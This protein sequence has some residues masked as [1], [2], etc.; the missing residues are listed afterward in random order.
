MVA[1]AHAA[2][3]PHVG[4]L[5]A[6][7]VHGPHTV[8]H[9]CNHTIGSPNLVNG[10]RCAQITDDSEL[11]LALASGLSQADP[12]VGAVVLVPGS[13]HCTI[14]RPAACRHA[15]PSCYTRLQSQPA[16]RARRVQ[17]WQEG[18]YGAHLPHLIAAHTHP[19]SARFLNGHPTASNPA[20]RPRSRRASRPEHVTH[21]CLTELCAHGS[22]FAFVLHASRPHTALCGWRPT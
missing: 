1:Q 16:T 18:C 5:F 3:N 15:W 17:T 21:T 10:L 2:A 22:S 4:R 19:L 9:G 12:Q 6:H 13:V 8:S 14:H 20:A 11:A 7:Y